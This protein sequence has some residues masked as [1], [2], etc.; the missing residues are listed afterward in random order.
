MSF[1]SNGAEDGYVTESSETSGVGGALN[2]GGQQLRAGDSPADRQIKVILSFDTSALPDGATILS[3]TVRVR[4]QSVR[5]TNPFTSLGPCWIDVETGPFGGNA[6]LEASDFQAAATVA[7][8][9]TLSNALRKGDWST[10][11]LG[12]EGLAA[13][14]KAG[15]T[16]LRLGFE[17]D[18]NDNRKQDTMG[19]LSGNRQN[20]AVRPELVVTYAP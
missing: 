7:R 15:T 8:A 11:A 20:P 13:I 9:G 12:A 1:R 2:S 18:D 4:R 19:W 5:G 14:N 17:R 6:A 10:G 3:A 16:Q